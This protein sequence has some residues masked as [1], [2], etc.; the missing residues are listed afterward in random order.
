MTID[1]CI[2]VAPRIYIFICW[3]PLCY[4]PL[5][6]WED[7]SNSAWAVARL[8][9]FSKSAGHERLRGHNGLPIRMATQPRNM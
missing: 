2:D 7:L 8:G 4:Q 9:T 3:F 1:D 5:G 6:P